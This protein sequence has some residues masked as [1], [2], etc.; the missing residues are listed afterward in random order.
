MIIII[1]KGHLSIDY[2]KLIEWCKQN[3]KSPD[4]SNEPYVVSFQIN[5]DGDEPENHP[6]DMH[7]IPNE[8]GIFVAGL[9]TFKYYT[10]TN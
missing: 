3:I 10:Y 1:D 2:A 8:M 7:K 5:I 4:D 9:G 6:L